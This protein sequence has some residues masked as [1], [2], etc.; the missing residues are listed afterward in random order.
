[1]TSGEPAYYGIDDSL[2]STSNA[3]A[4]HLFGLI[5][6]AIMPKTAGSLQVL[7]RLSSLIFIASLCSL[8]V[9]C[10]SV[11]ILYGIAQHRGD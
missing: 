8:C 5:L 6:L 4:K 7:Q 3:C 9:L 11:V 2:S 10:V 1:M